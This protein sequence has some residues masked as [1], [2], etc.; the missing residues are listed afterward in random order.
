MK[1]N[2]CICINSG[3]DVYQT[4][5]TATA[6]SSSAAT[7]ADA[8]AGAQKSQGIGKVLEIYQ[9]WIRIEW[10]KNTKYNW[11]YKSANIRQNFHVVQNNSIIRTLYG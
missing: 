3:L 8:A 10:I 5:Y 6:A 11:W 9:D 7:S 2:D 4:V 1:V